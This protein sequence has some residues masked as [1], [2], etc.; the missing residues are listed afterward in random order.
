MTLPP[1]EPDT[2]LF[3]SEKLTVEDSCEQRNSHKML[4][5][6]KKKEKKKKR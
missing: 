3:T 4:K 2:Q 1:A 5:L 6:K